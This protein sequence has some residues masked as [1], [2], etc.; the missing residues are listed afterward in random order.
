MMIMP[1]GAVMDT[2][3]FCVKAIEVI[4]GGV[5]RNEGFIW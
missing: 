2:K 3:P 1:V 5:Q 4:V